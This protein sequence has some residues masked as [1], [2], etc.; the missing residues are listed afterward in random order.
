MKGFLISALLLILAITPA[1][2]DD[3]PTVSDTWTMMVYNGCRENVDDTPG[4][5]EL[6]L[7][8]AYGNTYNSA[9][10]REF[11]EALIDFALGRTTQK[12]LLHAMDVATYNAAFEELEAQ[13]K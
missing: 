11:Y 12:G 8:C 1:F 9:Q 2:G 4:G 10:R 3:R 13:A 6:F 7:E 5:F